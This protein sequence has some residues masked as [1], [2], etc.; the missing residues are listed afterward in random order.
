MNLRELFDRIKAAVDS[1]PVL[2]DAIETRII[3]GIPTEHPAIYVDGIYD[4][5]DVKTGDAIYF[6][7]N[8]TYAKTTGSLADAEA[9][10]DLAGRLKAALPQHGIVG[11][12]WLDRSGETVHRA[13]FNCQTRL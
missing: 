6:N 13:L 8:L 5:D 11:G 10:F 9:F 2:Q 7:V 12:S 3:L 1:D 4:L